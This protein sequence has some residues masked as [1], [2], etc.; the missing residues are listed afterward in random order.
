MNAESYATLCDEVVSVVSK[1]YIGNEEV[2]RKTLAAALVNGNVL[3]EDHPGL[4]KTLLAKAF[5]RALGLEYRRV[6]FTPDL[7]PSDIIGTK[8]WRQNLGT[9]ELI[10][11]P[12][13]THVLLADEINRAPPKT[14]S[15]L[16]EAMEE[17]QVTIEGDTMKLEMPF[18]VIAT[19]NPIEYEGTYPLP[20]AQLDRFLLRMSVGYPKSLD[21]EVGILKA[22]ISWGKDDP[23]ADMEP[24]MD[25]GTFLEMQAFVEHEV[26]IHDEVLKY[27]AG[28]VREVRKDERVEAGP[29]PRGALALLKVSKANAMMN[30]RDFVVPD[31]VKRYVI[32]ALAHRIV[33]GAEYA[34]EGVSGREVVEAAVKRVPVPKE[35][36]REE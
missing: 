3:F 17:R 12:I 27:I 36:E 22:R 24:V 32:D 23:T 35:F 14:Q 34:F 10:K 9:F 25:R 16:L 5:G 21:D 4:G 13:F 26:F 15:A 1:V 20:E 19:Q 29:S 33:L 18:F 7:L 6:Q 2:V 28:I 30:G 8:V 11:G 31:D